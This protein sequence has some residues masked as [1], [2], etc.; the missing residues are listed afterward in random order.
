MLPVLLTLLLAPITEISLER[1]PCYGTCPI[2]KVTIRSDGTAEYTGTRFVKLT[3]K[4]RGRVSREDFERLAGLV[5]QARFFDLKDRYS[6][7]VT[8][9][10]TLTTTV[11]RGEVTRSVSD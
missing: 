2:D 6:R 8:D 10:P 1:S 7:P 4:H 5:S 3:G 9:N 11:K